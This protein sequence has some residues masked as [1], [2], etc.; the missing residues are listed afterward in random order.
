MKATLSSELDD[1]Q[2]TK[3]QLEK[4]VEEV[5]KQDSEHNLH[6]GQILMSVDN[7]FLRCT[8]KRKNIHHSS[9]P[10]D[11]D[12]KKDDDGHDDGDDNKKKH[13]LAVTQLRTIM[14]YIKDYKDI[15]EELKRHRRADAAR[16]GPP[17]QALAEP[18]KPPEPQFIVEQTDSRADRGSHTSGSQGNTRELSRVTGAGAGDSARVTE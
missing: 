8:T 7:L 12:D 15:V 3:N 5:T 6:F 13:K 4:Q 9:M 2:K 18:A 16:R 1:A 11:E 17:Q 10:M 14:D